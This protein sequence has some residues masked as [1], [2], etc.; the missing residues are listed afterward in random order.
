MGE[1]GSNIIMREK[2]C[3]LLGVIL[4]TVLRMIFGMILGVILGVIDDIR[5]DRCRWHE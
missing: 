1:R 3:V 5:R 4:R 2:F